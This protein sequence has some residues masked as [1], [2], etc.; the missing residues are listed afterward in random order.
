MSKR[1]PQNDIPGTV[2]PP[3]DEFQLVDLSELT[4]YDLLLAAIG[5][6][7][8]GAVVVGHVTAVP[9]WATLSAGG[10]VSM[11]MLADALAVNPP[12]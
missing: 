9:F 7:I 8:L 6:A 2:R 11:P 1:R 10:L 12:E 3:P 4:R 5:F